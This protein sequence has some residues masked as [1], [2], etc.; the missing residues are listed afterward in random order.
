MLKN[1]KSN[2]E[3]EKSK[4]EDILFA[5]ILICGVVLVLAFF[6][7]LVWD[8]ILVYYCHFKAI[9][10]LGSCLLSSL[11]IICKGR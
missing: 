10:F 1:I 7:M 11:I 4:I 3:E 6:I 2:T 5:L 8:N 9:S